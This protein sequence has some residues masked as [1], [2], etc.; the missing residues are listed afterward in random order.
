MGASVARTVRRV[1]ML[2][3]IMPAPL[4]RPAMRYSTPGE[5]GSSK[6][7]DMSLGKV[8]VVQIAFAQFSQWLWESPAL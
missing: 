4:V 1:A 2:G 3:A 6:V 8:S 7:R 5:D